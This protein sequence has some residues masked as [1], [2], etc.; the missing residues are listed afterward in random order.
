MKHWEYCIVDLASTSAKEVPV[1]R[2]NV[3]GAAGWELVTIK[4]PQLAILKRTTAERAKRSANT[5][6][7][8]AS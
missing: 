2:L 3:L 1:Q 5:R 6:R 8:S 7:S 4:A